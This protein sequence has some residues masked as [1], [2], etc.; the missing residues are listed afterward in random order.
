MEEGAKTYEIVETQLR[1]EV[2]LCEAGH[3]SLLHK[4]SS[5]PK[6]RQNL[7]LSFFHSLRGAIFSVVSQCSVTLSFAS[8]NRS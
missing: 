8:L 6:S 3:G 1:S 7:P 2:K 4:L 5:G